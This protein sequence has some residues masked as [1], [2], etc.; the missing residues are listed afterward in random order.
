MPTLRK[1]K[2]TTDELEF[3]I[4]LYIDGAM[5]PLE[6][7]ALEEVLATDQPAREMLAEY[8]RLNDALKTQLARPDVDF[9]LLNAQISRS[10]AEAEAPAAPSF[11]LPLS[12][13]MRFVAIAAS[14]VILVGLVAVIL[15]NGVGGNSTSGSGGPSV[16]V[17]PQNPPVGS[18]VVEGPSMNLASGAGSATIDVS[19]GAPPGMASAGSWQD[20]AIITRTPRVVIESSALPMQDTGTP[21]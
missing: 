21:Y 19:I 14:V 17:N 18:I 8:R 13:P 3:A 11:R 1:M 12:M 4:S 20:Q 16:A 9:D 15:R 5:K 7:A 10:L 2:Y 6:A